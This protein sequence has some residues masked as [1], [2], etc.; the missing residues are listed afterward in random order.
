[1]DPRQE[2]QVALQL[3]DKHVKRL[4]HT[5]KE[6][7][8]IADAKYQ[9]TAFMLKNALRFASSPSSTP[10]YRERAMQVK[11]TLPPGHSKIAP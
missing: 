1:M 2:I 9:V 8:K 5:A 3:S 7:I 4:I 10:T 6:M 11:S